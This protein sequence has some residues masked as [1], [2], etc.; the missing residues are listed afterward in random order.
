MPNLLSKTV[1]KLEEKKLEI[2]LTEKE[3]EA[4]KA[5]AK[6]LE[7]KGNSDEKKI[8][9]IGMLPIKIAVGFL[10][11]AWVLKTFFGL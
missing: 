10:I 1:A 4:S 2:K 8:H 7:A 9:A 3:A 6:E 5:K 11:T